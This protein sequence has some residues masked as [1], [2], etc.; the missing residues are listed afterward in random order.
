[1]SITQTEGYQ[2]GRFMHFTASAESQPLK[3]KIRLAESCPIS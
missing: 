3:N 2:E 1:M